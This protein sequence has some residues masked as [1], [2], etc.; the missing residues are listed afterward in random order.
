MTGL[1]VGQDV[2]GPGEHPFATKYAL[3]SPQI[4]IEPNIYLDNLVRDFQLWGGTS[5]SA[6]STRRASWRRCA[7]RS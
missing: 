5:S 6:S 7:S 3:R 2:L 4:R 1:T